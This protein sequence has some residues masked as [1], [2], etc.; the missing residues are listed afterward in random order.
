MPR[1]KPASPDL[2]PQITKTPQSDGIRAEA[3]PKRMAPRPPRPTPREPS[4]EA[5]R[6]GAVMV[7]GRDGEQLTRR[8]TTVGDIHHVPR[9]EIPKGWDYQWNTVTVTGQDMREEQMVMMQNGW[10]PVPAS[11]HA[12]R[13]TPPEFTGAIIVKG[14]R[15]EERPTALGDEARAEDIANAK[16]QVRDQTDVLKLSKKLPEGM[17]INSR[18]FKGTGGEVRM[19][20]DPGL[21]I[22]H[23]THQIEE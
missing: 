3:A 5:A 7:A 17:A 10:R 22:P 14:L 6:D 23:P 4:R 21:D 1:K 16:A 9:E 19:S 8:R 20:I 12:G 15:L 18:K 11:R 13:W 2:A